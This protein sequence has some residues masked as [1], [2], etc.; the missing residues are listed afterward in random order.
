MKNGT[1]E[2]VLPHEQKGIGRDQIMNPPIRRI[3]LV[4]HAIDIAMLIT[5]MVEDLLEEGGFVHHVQNLDQAVRTLGDEQFDVVLL[6]VNIP[7]SAGAIRQLARIDATVPIVVLADAENE[8]A[9]IEAM[10]LGAED[11]LIR[12]SIDPDTLSRSLRY[13]AERKRLASRQRELEKQ[14]VNVLSDEQIRIGQELHDGVS[15]SLSG[16]SMMAQSLSRRLRAISEQEAD[17]AASIA[18]G[19]QSTVREL[20]QIMRGLNPLEVE[21]YGLP[22]AL[23][24]HC[25]RVQESVHVDIRLH[26]DMDASRISPDMATHLYRIA[27][28]AVHNA[29]RHGE[30]QTVKVSLTQQGSRC[31]LQIVDN[32]SGFDTGTPYKGFGL[33]I[34]AYRVSL[35]RGKLEV[36]SK[37]NQ[38]AIV[39]CSIPLVIE[40]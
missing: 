28:E 35:M 6:D 22:D 9:S 17:Q 30:A 7:D 18:K 34:M 26:C 36:H 29:T 13:A 23:K 3:L 33:R 14:I 5:T 12:G 19:L 27:Q 38:G 37:I 11:F 32:G 15:Q 21:S 20:R 2:D 40:S 25:E 8:K 31:V 1:K 16:L 10:Q 39:R 24:R 4:E